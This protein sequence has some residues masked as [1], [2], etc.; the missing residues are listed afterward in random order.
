MVILVGVFGN[1]SGN[2]LGYFNLAIY[3]A[4]GYDSNTQFL[5]NLMLTILATLSAVTGAA[6]S[7]R[8]PRRKVLIV[9]SILCA[10]WLG[11]NGGLSKVWT[12]NYKNGIIDLGVGRGAVAAFFLFGITY[13]FTYV[14]LLTLY[15]V[16]TTFSSLL[17]AI[18][19]VFTGR[20]SR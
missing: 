20:V 5:L 2:G 1:F 18:T 4:V 19:D 11:I 9:G 15:T 7:D 16:C 14:P 6:L 17:L 13:S 12:D 8:M 3:E 10:L